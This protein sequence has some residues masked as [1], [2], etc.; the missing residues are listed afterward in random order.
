PTPVKCS[1]KLSTDSVTVVQNTGSVANVGVSILNQTAAETVEAV[2]SAPSQVAAAHWN[3]N[4]YVTS[5]SI[6]LNGTVQFSVA[7]LAK[8][9]GYTY[10]IQF[11][12]SNCTSAKL[13][14]KV[15]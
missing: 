8:N 7:S 14:V 2:S 3:G 13:T 9:S 5:V 6:P 10:E 12:S 11:R 1:V 15:Q 4:K